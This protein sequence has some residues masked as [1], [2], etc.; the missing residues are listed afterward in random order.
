MTKEGGFGQDVTCK[1]LAE[2]TAPIRA[3]LEALKESTRWIPVGERLPKEFVNVLVLT[4]LN[5]IDISCQ[6]YGGHWDHCGQ[7]VTHWTPLPERPD[8]LHSAQAQVAGRCEA[9]KA[10]GEA[11][12]ARGG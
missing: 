4:K 1:R 7:N 6:Y 12:E 3:Q 10:E 8:V 2:I 9:R 11:M 5:R